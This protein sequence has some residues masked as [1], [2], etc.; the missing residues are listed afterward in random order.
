MSETAVISTKTAYPVYIGSLLLFCEQFRAV[1]L[2]NYT[3]KNTVNGDTVFT[4]TGKKVLRITMKGRI[5]NLRYP[6]GMLVIADTVL[7]EETGF[8]M[9]YRGITFSNCRLQSFTA[10][11]MGENYINF[12]VTVITP[13]HPV[14]TE[15]G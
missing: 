5:C 14:F 10:E 8:T 7:R 13:D 6:V 4:G 2:R 9:E 3:E 12:S 11:D 15:E 1:G